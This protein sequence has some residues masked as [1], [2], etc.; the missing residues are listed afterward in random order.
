MDDKIRRF[1]DQKETEDSL[2]AEFEFSLPARI[3]RSLEAKP[4]GI[5]PFTHFAAVSAECTRL[6]RDGHF[7]GCVSLAQSVAE[8]IARF[9]C[10]KNGWKPAR[11]FEKNVATLV[12]RKVID[13]PTQRIF[14]TIW[15]KRNDFHHLNSNVPTDSAELERLAREV[16][17]CL[18]DL[19]GRVFR[20]RIV[21]GK[22]HPEDPKLWPR[23]GD[24]VD[25]YLN[26]VP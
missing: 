17:P 6:Y 5:V 13:E 25:V 7:Y 9:L 19:E 20:F 4:A 23:D 3:E 16:V 18:V 22:L 12:G 26:L 8:A 1:I 10:E 15:E 11:A 2:R 21:D 24:H 14:L